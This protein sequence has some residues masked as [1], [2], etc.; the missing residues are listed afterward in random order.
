MPWPAERLGFGRVNTFE[1]Y[2]SRFAAPGTPGRVRAGPWRAPIALPDEYSARGLN[3]VGRLPGWDALKPVQSAL[4]HCPKY[5]L[6]C[7]LGKLYR[8]VNCA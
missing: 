1:R 6:N 4:D 5:L 2:A 8:I 7:T 3:L